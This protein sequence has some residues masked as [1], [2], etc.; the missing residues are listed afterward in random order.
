MADIYIRSMVASDRDWVAK[1]IR[2]L[3]GDS[4]VV[5]HGAVYYPHE[6]PGFVAFQDGEVAGL[7]TY[8]VDGESCEIVT[9]NSLRPAS[10]IGTA[11][12]DAV[13]VAARQVGCKRL[14][15]ITTNDNLNALRFYQKRG[16]VLAALHRNAVE[17]S[18]KLKPAIPLIGEDGIPL[19]DELELEMPL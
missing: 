5:G 19:R 8:C 2:E 4:L 14:W 7:L 11:L 16:F 6:L 1:L 9:I 10:G 17:Q 18:R 12:I 13:R 15:L 3:W